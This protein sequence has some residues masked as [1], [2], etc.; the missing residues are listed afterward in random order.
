MRKILVAA[1]FAAVCA[2]ATSAF[3]GDVVLDNTTVTASSTAKNKADQ[4]AVSKG[5]YSISQA[6]M[7]SIQVA[8]TATI[9]IRKSTL[10]LDS[11]LTNSKNYAFA[12]AD[13]SVAQA[14]MS[15]LQAATTCN[16]SGR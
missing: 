15:S 12:N 11:T 5:K 13:Y 4:E 1:T 16:C 9:D 8:G 2:V 3:A 10:T 6:G 7:S 14:G